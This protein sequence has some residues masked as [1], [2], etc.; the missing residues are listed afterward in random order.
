MKKPNVRVID[1]VLW[2]DDKCIDFPYPVADLLI[3]DEKI[4][5]RV[6]SDSPSEVID[7]DRNI[8]ALNYDGDVLWRVEKCPYGGEMDRTYVSIY[9]VGS[10]GLAAGNW[11]GYDFYIDLN[12]GTITVKAFTK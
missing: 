1:W 5:I 10:A 9:K 4:I 2:I 11:I 3:F 8:Y 12:D 6:D 7:N